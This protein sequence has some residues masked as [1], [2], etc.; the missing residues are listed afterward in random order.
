MIGAREI[1]MLQVEKPIHL[2]EPQS[3]LEDA[4]I[5]KLVHF[6]DLTRSVVVV[7]L[8]HG[9]QFACKGMVI[10]VVDIIEIDWGLR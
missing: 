9:Q 8:G 7:E 6:N 4:P 2:I 3:R 10:D 1:A 5:A